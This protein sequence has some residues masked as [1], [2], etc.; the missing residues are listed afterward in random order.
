VLSE[1]EKTTKKDNVGKE[2]LLKGFGIG[3]KRTIERRATGGVGR[4]HHSLHD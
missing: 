3:T 4:P 1:E 2:I